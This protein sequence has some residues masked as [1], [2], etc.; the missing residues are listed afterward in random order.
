MKKRLISA[1]SALLIFA[2]PAF[3]QTS[4]VPPSGS[5]PMGVQRNEPHEQRKISEYFEREV[6]LADGTEL[7]EILDMV[8]DANNRITG[9]VVEVESQRGMGERRVSV[10]LERLKME[11]DRLVLDMTVEQL[12][13]LPTQPA[14]GGK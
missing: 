5:A 6:Y 7:G 10:P 12:Q 8:V 14:D 9:A 13:Q 1:T 4:D 3:A 2:H 11:P